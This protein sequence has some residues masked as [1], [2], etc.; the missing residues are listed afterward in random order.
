MKTTT[1]FAIFFFFSFSNFMLAQNIPGTKSK[2]KKQ[3]TINISSLPQI[4]NEIGKGIKVPNPGWQPP[5]WSF[6]ESNIIYKEDNSKSKVNVPKQRIL[7]PAPDTSFAGLMDNG[8]SIPPDVNGAAGL[9]HLMQTLNTDVRISDK[10]GNDLFTTSLSAW[11]SPMP[12]SGSTFDPKIVY[13]PFQNRW[14]MITPSGSNS[15]STKIYIGVS[16][17]TTHWTNGISIG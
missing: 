17:T 15:T 1:A 6:A 3:T 7:S 5:D 8:T 2:A 4:S 14:I 12:G 9:N 16:T 11:W 10:N 13:D